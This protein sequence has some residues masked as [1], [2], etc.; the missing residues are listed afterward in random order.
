[1]TSIGKRITRAKAC[2]PTDVPPAPARLRPARSL[3]PSLKAEG[4]I[5]AI[6]RGANGAG[7]YLI[8]EGSS[9]HAVQERVDSFPFVVEGLM[10][11]DYDEVYPI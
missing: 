6:Y 11:V 8:L 10:S 3:C 1:V 9:V 7:V 2:G 4:V 5:T